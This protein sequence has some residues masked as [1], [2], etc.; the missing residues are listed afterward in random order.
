LFTPLVA[1]CK[2]YLEYCL[3]KLCLKPL[4]G[5]AA[6]C[7]D[8]HWRFLR[9]STLW[10][11]YIDKPVS[12][13]CQNP[14]LEC[15]IPYYSPYRQDSK[16]VYYF[17]LVAMVTIQ[18]LWLAKHKNKCNSKTTSRNG[19]IIRGVV[20]DYIPEGLMEPDFLFRCHGNR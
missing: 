8:L 17:A 15:H 7:L 1:L 10:S 3:N 12:H 11:P 5:V 13:S 14:G 9:G 19:F 18:G 20:D 6:T 2:S 16:L 4:P